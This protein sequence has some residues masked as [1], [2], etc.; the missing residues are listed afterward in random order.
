M[1]S[2]PIDGGIPP[3]VDVADLSGFAPAEFRRGDSPVW[4]ALLSAAV[5][6]HQAA[7]AASTAAIGQTDPTRATGEFLGQAAEDRGLAARQGETSSQLRER[8]FSSSWAVS[9]T[10]I[11]D[12]VNQ[13]LG[14]FTPIQA[15]VFESIQDRAFL[16]ASTGVQS[17]Q[18]FLGRNPSYP[19][20]RYDDGPAPQRRN[21]MPGGLR[22]FSGTVGRLF[23]VRVP[24]L[25]AMDTDVAGF[26]TILPTTALPNGGGWALTI[27]PDNSNDQLLGTAY[28]DPDTSPE[29]V[30]NA[31]ADSVNE[32]R[33]H[34]IQWVGFV[35]DMT[36]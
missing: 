22:L 26:A 27:A 11:V 31:I 9:R 8:M 14:R 4:D 12:R 36:Y 29:N 34:G 23:V 2:V 7:H 3:V 20:R 18:S 30:Y 35:E 5:S 19:D 28:R 21:S 15:Q 13:L 10:A 24:D 1:A 33:A 16:R 32:L 25:S 17:W 6:A